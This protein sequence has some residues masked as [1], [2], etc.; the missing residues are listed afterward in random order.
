M[1]VL[2]WSQIFHCKS[3]QI[4]PDPQGQWTLQSMVWSGWMS[5]PSKTKLL[6]LLP[7]RMK[8]IPSKMKVLEWSQQIFHC[9]SMQIFPDPQGQWTLQSMAW[10]GWMS[11][12]SK[13]KWLSLLPARMKKIPSKMKALEWSQHYSLIFDT[14]GQLTPNLVMESWQ[15]S[16][17]IS[18]LLL[19]SWE[20]C[21]PVVHISHLYNCHFHF[22]LSFGTHSHTGQCKRTGGC[23]NELVVAFYST[24]GGVKG[25]KI[26]TCWLNL[27]FINLHLFYLWWHL[28]HRPPVTL[29]FMALPSNW[30]IKSWF[31][32]QIQQSS[33]VLLWQ[34]LFLV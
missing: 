22:L 7:A 2:E 13:T 32:L 3:M 20:F 29:Q 25:K 21:V 14:Q 17:C 24:G 19:P 11:N 27:L 23:Y 26:Y 10:S 12:P 1:K 28:A 5:N 15:N 16:N 9:K 18:L 4:F 33:G 34:V 8:K 30:W 6:S 31:G